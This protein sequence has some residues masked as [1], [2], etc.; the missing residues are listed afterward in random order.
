MAETEY[1]D[2]TFGLLDDSLV[3][4]EIGDILGSAEVSYDNPESKPPRLPGGGRI[5]ANIGKR[6]HE[7]GAVLATLEKKAATGTNKYTVE[8]GWFAGKTYAESGES[9]AAVAALQEYGGMTYAPNFSNR[10][11][12]EPENGIINVPPRPFLRPTIEQNGREYLREAG[13]GVLRALLNDKDPKKAMQSVGEHVKQDLIDAIDEV[14]NPP[15]APITVKR[16]E[17]LGNYSD[18]PLIDTGTMR[19]SIE[20]KVGWR[21][22]GT[23]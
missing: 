7:L 17:Y 11:A 13:M 14:N 1:Y 16:R 9:V 23:C 2:S 8:I 10:K 15:L 18:K 12:S 20:V 4:P 19:N 3:A 21:V 5:A 6:T 22:C